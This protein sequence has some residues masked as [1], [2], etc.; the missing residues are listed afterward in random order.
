MRKVKVP[1]VRLFTRLAVVLV[2]VTA[3][4]SASAGGPP[5]GTVTFLDAGS[6]IGSSVVDNGEAT[7]T[8]A[9]LTPGEHVITA[10]Y[11]GAPGF[12]SSSSPE[13]TQVVNTTPEAP[14]ATGG[15]TTSP[16]TPGGGGAT[17]TGTTPG[18]LA[19]T[20]ASWT[21]SAAIAGSVLV[22]FGTIFVLA[23][24]ARRRAIAQHH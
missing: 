11:L 14:P 20:G 23:G 9:E 13:L 7:F 15:A 17:A 18:T 2:V 19:R 22:A 6:P 5:T 4:V 16:T 21:R 3:T 1:S 24:S 12:E 8:T 10:V